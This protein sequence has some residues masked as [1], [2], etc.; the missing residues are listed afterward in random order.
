[1]AERCATLAEFLVQAPEFKSVGPVSTGTITVDVQ[2]APGDEITISNMFVAP[3]VVETLV[4]DTDFAIGADVDETAANISTA[5]N[6]GLPSTL[7][8]SGFLGNIVYLNSKTTG[9]CTLY[10]LTTDNAV[11]FIL[12]SPTLEGGDAIVD[13]ELECACSQ[14]NIE[15]WGIKSDCAHIYLT[16]HFMAVRTGIGASGIVNNKKIDQIQVGF[17]VTAPSDAELGSTKWG[18][19]YLL[20]KRTLLIL[21][22]PGRRVLPIL[23]C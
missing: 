11:A 2:P 12:S 1:M 19:S 22:V 23:S 8:D 17:A 14:I 7:V 13:F 20:L 10:G 3:P 5:L 16:G 4:A 9:S 6:V 15:C 18:R 21:P